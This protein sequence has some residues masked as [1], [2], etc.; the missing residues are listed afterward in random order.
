MAVKKIGL[1]D[2]YLSR[3]KFVGSISWGIFSFLIGRLFIS[4][5]G[6]SLPWRHVV[7]YLVSY[8]VAAFSTRV[9]IIRLH[10]T[11]QYWY[12]AGLGIVVGAV[13][14]I[15]AGFLVKFLLDWS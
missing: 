6:I 4:F 2:S 8:L 5:F 7:L 1:W 12:L 10:G 15:A 3:E 11:C 9:F 13:V 14:G